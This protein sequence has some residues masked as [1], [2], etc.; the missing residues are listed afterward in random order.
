M[1]KIAKG[2]RYTPGKVCYETVRGRTEPCPRCALSEAITK[3]ESVRHEFTEGDITVEISAIP[4]F[5]H[6]DTNIV[7][8]LMK[9]EDI[10]DKKRIEHL[11]FEV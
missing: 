2:R 3:G 8:G 10:S 4:L 6:T 7:G 11:M 9:V 5:D 1:H